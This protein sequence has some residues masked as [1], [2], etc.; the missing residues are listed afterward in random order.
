MS[1]FQELSPDASSF[2]KS[3]R[4]KRRVGPSPLAL[5][6]V[7][8][9]AAFESKATLGSPISDVLSP[10]F[11]STV[12]NVPRAAARRKERVTVQYDGKTPPVLQV[13]F[14]KVDMDV[15]PL[16][17]SLPNLYNTLN[18]SSQG[19]YNRFASEKSPLPVVVEDPR[20]HSVSLSL[21]DRDRDWDRQLFY[22]ATFPAPSA[23][24]PPRPARDPRRATPTKAESTFPIE[25]PIPSSDTG[26]ASPHLLHDYAGHKS[27]RS[28]GPAQDTPRTSQ[29]IPRP[30]QDALDMG[31]E[32]TARSVRTMSA[33]SDSLDA[34]REIAA[35]FPKLPPRVVPAKASSRLQPVS[36]VSRP[37]ADYAYARPPGLHGESDADSDTEWRTLARARSL[38]R[39]VEQA[40]ETAAVT[41]ISPVNSIKRKP[42][43]SSTEEHADTAHV[44]GEMDK[45]QLA[46]AIIARAAR[47]ARGR[48]HTLSIDDLSSVY[49]SSDDG[50]FDAGEYSYTARNADTPELTSALDTPATIAD[51]VTPGLRTPAWARGD[52]GRVQGRPRV[53]ERSKDP[54]PQPK[55]QTSPHPQR[56][57]KQ[58]SPPPRVEGA[59]STPTGRHS[60]RLTLLRRELRASANDSAV[61]SAT[62][63]PELQAPWLHADPLTELQTIGSG[64][65]HVDSED[66][67]AVLDEAWRRAGLT[68]IK[69]VSRVR[70]HTTPRAEQG[71]GVRESL[72]AEEEDDISLLATPVEVQEQSRERQMSVSASLR[73][74]AR[75]DSGV[76][77][78]E[79]RK[80]VRQGILR[81]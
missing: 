10:E 27:A 69:S 80:L 63:E 4:T 42:A 21:S 54:R 46:Q 9:H 45:G 30:S 2:H 39:R 6:G 25:A 26:G 29:D 76:L 70:V 57:P 7:S 1:T 56:Q 79:D 13:R 78:E 59:Q 67:D 47:S 12:F 11:D 68:R 35:R 17:P 43:P 41:D 28:P 58:R 44:G 34:V 81:A 31:H 22:P 60:R 37:A 55:V 33:A 18:L 73:K 5:G 51:A 75:L 14:S 52:E 20:E 61:A 50:S 64:P 66:E 77:G 53:V 3:Q 40:R 49:S 15:H 38:Q 32:V 71:F 62:L 72:V 65:L 19:H 23:P 36:T 74:P 16:P 8:N 24:A 48:K